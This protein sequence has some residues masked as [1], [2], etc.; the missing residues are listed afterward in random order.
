[1]P[2]KNFNAVIK[3]FLLTHKKFLTPETVIGKKNQQIKIENIF[4]S[5][6]WEDE[7]LSPTENTKHLFGNQSRKGVF[8]FWTI[9]ESFLQKRLC[10]NANFGTFVRV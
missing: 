2:I 9:F 4:Y 1:V 8:L 6:E 7:K 10:R 3:F 5:G